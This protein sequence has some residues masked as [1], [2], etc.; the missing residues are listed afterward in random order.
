M[1]PGQKLNPGPLDQFLI[2]DGPGSPGGVVIEMPMRPRPIFLFIVNE[3]KQ[4]FWYPHLAG[5][6]ALA[7][8]DARSQ[9]PDR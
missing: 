3:L 2:T 8:S 4:V 1:R 7:L 6:D 9:R 5:A